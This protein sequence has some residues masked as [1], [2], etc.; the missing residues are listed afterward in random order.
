M[1]IKL[2][3]EKISIEIS[4]LGAELTS[5]KKVEN[6]LELLWQGNG[7]YWSGQSPLLFP[8]IGGI[9]DNQ[10]ILRQGET[11]DGS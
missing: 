5:L 10:Y 7:M 3:N 9:P 8:I 11:G 4:S 6:D 1:E 2:E